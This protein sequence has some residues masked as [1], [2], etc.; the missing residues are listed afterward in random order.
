MGWDTWDG[1]GVWLL[2][3]VRVYDDMAY[4]VVKHYDVVVT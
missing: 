1:G 4:T 3:C 2:C